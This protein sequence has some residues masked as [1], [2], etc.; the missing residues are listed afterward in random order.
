MNTWPDALAQPPLAC[1]TLQKIFQLFPQNSRS[2]FSRDK[3]SVS[4]VIEGMQKQPKGSRLLDFFFN[5][6]QVCVPRRCFELTW[7]VCLA[8]W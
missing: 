1:V 8:G 5:N 6:C 2:W 7:C 3:N 4:S